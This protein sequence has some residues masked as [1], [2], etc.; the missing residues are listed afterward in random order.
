MDWPEK[1]L[2]PSSCNGWLYVVTP[3]VIKLLLDATSRAPFV[4]M[5]DTYVTGILR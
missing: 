1:T 3:T 4:F 2:F 5:E